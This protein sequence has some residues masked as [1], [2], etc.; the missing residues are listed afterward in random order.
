MS[1]PRIGDGQAW[2]RGTSWLLLGGWVGAWVLFAFV[3]APT[4]FR[5]LP[6]THAAGQLVGP[7]LGAL[8]VYGAVAGVALALASWGLNRTGPCVWLP[9]VMSALCLASQFGVTA[10]IEAVRPLVF[11]PEGSPEMAARF[12]LLHRLSMGIYTAVGIAGFLLVA[13]HAR[14]DAAGR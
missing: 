7:V 11:G 8:H 2:L 6:S 4:A 5:V 10:Q 14:A 9:L 3:V 1:N 13:L 12:Q